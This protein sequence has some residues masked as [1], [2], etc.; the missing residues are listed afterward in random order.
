MGAKARAHVRLRVYRDRRGEW[1]WSAVARNGRIVADG[2]E[3]YSTKDHAVRAV[4]RFVAMM[5]A[6]GAAAPRLEVMP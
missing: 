6:T 3:G 2:A 5:K 1:R 4:R